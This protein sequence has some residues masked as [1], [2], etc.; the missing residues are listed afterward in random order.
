MILP[1]TLWVRFVSTG[2]CTECVQERNEKFLE[3]RGA[4]AEERLIKKQTAQ[5]KMMYAKDVL[6][7][8]THK[9]IGKIILSRFTS[10]YK[11]HKQAH[12]NYCEQEVYHTFYRSQVFDRI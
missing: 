6:T 10:F 5:E 3:D 1:I 11:F 8:L 2:G 7:N 12:I 4:K 9:V